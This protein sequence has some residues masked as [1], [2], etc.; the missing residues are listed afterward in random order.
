MKKKLFFFLLGASL[1]CFFVRIG[2]GVLKSELKN[3]HREIGNNLIKIKREYPRA[4]DTV[5]L[6]LDQLGKYYSFSKKIIS[7]KKEYKK[8]LKDEL[9]RGEAAK[10]ELAEFKTKMG[11][12]K[13]VMLDASEKLK[14]DSEKVSKLKVE[15]ESLSKEKEKFLKEKELFEIEKQTLVSERDSLIRERDALVRERDAVVREKEILEKN[16][17]RKK[18]ACAQAKRLAPRYI[19]ANG[20]MA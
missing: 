8:M 1:T 16:V 2:G 13:K 6:V 12:V 20:A 10:K 11:K 19:A 3:L 17:Q 7:K 15:K 5:Y 14:K 9:E 18:E 4:Q